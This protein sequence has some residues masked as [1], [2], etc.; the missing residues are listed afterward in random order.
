MSEPD[1]LATTGSDM[2]A[3]GTPRYQLRT[4]AGATV[5]YFLENLFR[6]LSGRAR[7][8]KPPPL[9][10]RSEQEVGRCADGGRDERTGPGAS[11]PPLRPRLSR[12]TIRSISVTDGPLSV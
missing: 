6:T 7:S 9:T 12:A 4:F 1:P 11:D 10:A 3:T 8:S 2:A 5:R